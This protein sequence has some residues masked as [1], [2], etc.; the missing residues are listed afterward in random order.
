MDLYKIQELFKI[1]TEWEAETIL[2][3][4][5]RLVPGSGFC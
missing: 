2:R 4:E 3:T 1:Q 5:N